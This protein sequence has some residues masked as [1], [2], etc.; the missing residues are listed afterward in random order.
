M[1]MSAVLM[2]LSQ[3]HPAPMSSI[4]LRTSCSAFMFVGSVC[5]YETWVLNGANYTTACALIVN[6]AET[7]CNVARFFMKKFQFVTDSYR[8]YTSLNRLCNG[9]R[10]CF[11]AAPSQKYLLRQ[12]KAMDY[13]LIQDGQGKMLF[14]E[15]ASYTMKDEDGNPIKAEELDVGLLIL[16]GHVLYAGTSYAFAL[17]KP[18][19]QRGQL[20]IKA[21]SR[22]RLTG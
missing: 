7:L 11:N 17:S 6:D 16:Y 15:R 14:Q 21:F 13:S 10:L 22:L 8:L 9:P 3:Q 18:S 12:I 1:A 20:P 5:Q 19:L 4:T 2:T